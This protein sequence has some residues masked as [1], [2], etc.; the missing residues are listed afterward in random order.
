[1]IQT[2]TAIPPAYQTTGAFRKGSEP[3]FSVHAAVSTL[4]PHSF[5]EAQ[6]GKHGILDF[7]VVRESL[8]AR[9]HD[10]PKP[11]FISRSWAIH[12]GISVMSAI[13]RFAMVV[14]SLLAIPAVGQSCLQWVNVTPEVTG[15]EPR[16]QFGMAYDADRERAIV[17]GGTATESS[18]TSFDDTWEWNGSSWELAKGSGPSQRFGCSMTFD[19]SRGVAVLFGGRHRSNFNPETWEWN[20][21]QWRLASIAGPAPRT[22]VAMAYD[23]ARQR[24]LMFGGESINQIRLG[25][26]WSWDGTSWTLMS[27]S[28]PGPRHSASMAFDSA[29]GTMILFGGETDAGANG[30]TWE[31]NGTSWS[32]LYIA[33]P[34]ARESAAMD[35]DTHRHVLVLYGGRLPNSYAFDGDVWELRSSLAITRH[36]QPLEVQAGRAAE[37][38]I[39]AAS[40]SPVTYQW[41][42]DGQPLSNGGNIFGAD[43]DTLTI[44]PAG[45][46]DQGDYDCIATSTCGDATSASASL[47]V[48]CYADCDISTGPGVLDVFDFLCWLNDYFRATPYAC[49]CDTSTGPGVC[50]I[51]D[52]ICF[53]NAFS[54]GCQ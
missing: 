50:D 16:S 30:E 24:V 15:P 8:R 22:N 32:R 54:A 6:Q 35:Y 13:S 29:R 33:G 41:R 9:P 18:E 39:T 34:S 26:T 42:R 53:G 11:L 46:G 44:D 4:K 27:Q 2:P 20:G 37:F 31:W 36:P 52:Y 1:M 19:E 49:E 51:F 17:F 45:L 38:S 48:T 28:G 3:R 47:T 5:P 14:M 25:D 12:G 23:A 10:D 40:A 43:T 7:P 21:T